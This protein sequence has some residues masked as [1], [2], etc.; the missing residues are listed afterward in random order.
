[1]EF[2]FPGFLPPEFEGITWWFGFH[3][4]LD[5]PEMLTCNRA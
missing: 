5:I 1:M 3:Q 4:T 2:A